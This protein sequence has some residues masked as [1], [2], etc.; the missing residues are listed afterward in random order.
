MLMPN[1]KLRALMKSV[2]HNQCYTLKT[3]GKC[4]Y[5]KTRLKQPLKNRQNKGLNDKW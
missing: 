3:C 1:M 2:G 4:Y 5:S